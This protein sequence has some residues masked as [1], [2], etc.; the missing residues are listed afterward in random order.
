M[1]NN[2]GIILFLTSLIAGFA[3]TNAK[4]VHAET[5][6]PKPLSD[7]D[8]DYYF[9]GTDSPLLNTSF[10]YL[11]RFHYWLSDKVDDFGEEADD[12]F[13]TEDS[14]DRTEG[15]R[16]DIM[17]PV[18]FHADGSIDTQL[19]FRTKI[20]LPRTNK[21]WHLMV[22]SARDSM[23]DLVSGGNVSGNNNNP[24]DTTQQDDG[25]DVGLRYALDLAG[26]TVTFVD[27]GLNFRNIVEPDPY[28]RVR[29]HYKWKLSPQWYTRMYQTLYWERYKGV[30]LKSRQLFDRQI[31]QRYLF[32]SR[33]E[34]EWR[35]DDQQYSLSQN[36]ILVD[37]VNA[38]RG[39]AYYIGWYWNWTPDAPGL[40]LNAYSLGMN[41]RERIYKKWL[42]FEIDPGVNFDSDSDFN[43]ADVSVKL[44]L[45]AQFYEMK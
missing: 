11:D 31:S 9:E 10:R 1:Q 39:L 33:T 42:F 28:A 37:Q 3:L 23:D 16:L 2:R 26:F 4:I 27:F 6:S 34:G 15:S 22:S 36:F 18:T 25:T 32:R 40:A 24:N 17:A 29:L 45:E 14:F 38:H 8:K 44:M 12:F 19:N 30:G 5:A 21:R 13:G 20:A 43:Q 7:D 35:D 41:W